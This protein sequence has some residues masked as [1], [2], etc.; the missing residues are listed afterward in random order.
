MNASNFWGNRPLLH[1]CYTLQIECLLQVFLSL[2]FYL[3]LDKLSNDVN[4]YC[5]LNYVAQIDFAVGYIKR[6]MIL[7]IARLVWEQ[8]ML[9]SDNQNL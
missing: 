5:R 2:R 6:Y 3:W 7:A 8:A 4:F 1:P 9:M